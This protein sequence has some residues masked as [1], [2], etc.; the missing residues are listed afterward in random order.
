[1]ISPHQNFINIAGENIKLSR[2]QR[3]LS[4]LGNRLNPVSDARAQFR[5]LELAKKRAAL[6]KWKTHAKLDE[7]LLEFESNFTKAGGKVIWALDAAEAMNSIISILK[8]ADADMVVKSK[9]LTS[10]EIDLKPSLKLA[11][12]ECVETDLGDYIQQKSNEPPFHMVMPAVHRS[13]ED[14]REI[15][16]ADFPADKTENPEAIVA[17]VRNVMRSKF[18]SANA[19]ITGANF[20]VADTGSV[21]ITENE[22]NAVLTASLPKLHIVVAGIEKLIPSIHD[23]HLF[24][25]L[26]SSH[27]TGQSLTAINNIITGPAKNTEIDG[28][29]EMY[30]IL[31][32]NGRSNILESTEQRQS[33]SCIR[34]GACLNVCPVYTFSGGHAYG[35]E[36]MG[37][38]GAVLMP[39]KYALKDFKHL[40]YAS[41]LCGKCTEVCPLKID[42]HKLLLYSRKD[43]VNADLVTRSEKLVFYF[44]KKRMLNREKMNRGQKTK[45]FLLSKFFKKAWGPGRAMPQLAR[46]SFNESWRKK[47]PEL[48][49]K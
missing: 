22:G 7:Y 3:M 28:P 21:C 29:G 42:L 19:G 20:L 15:F 14:I 11:K 18:T 47:F 38:I 24:L 44:W 34:C 17:L 27:G 36:A 13:F 1:M 33:L 9:S 12:I 41:T 25:P 6:I 30:V 40:S 26:L 49:R 32:D 10:D 35:P 39:H 37:P 31:L 8:K 23:L 43:I 16:S 48:D 46:L 45:N 5:N 2:H 4:L